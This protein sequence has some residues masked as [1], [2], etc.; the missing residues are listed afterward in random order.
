MNYDFKI[1]VY[2]SVTPGRT[3]KIQISARKIKANP[4]DNCEVSVRASAETYLI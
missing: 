1:V 2:T 4:C 3:N